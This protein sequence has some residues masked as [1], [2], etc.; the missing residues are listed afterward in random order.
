[1]SFNKDE[2]IGQIGQKVVEEY[3]N[4]MKRKGAIKDWCETKHFI[5]QHLGLN[6]ETD[7][8]LWTRKGTTAGSEVKCLAGTKW[9]KKEGKWSEQPLDTHCIEAWQDDAKTRRPGWI[10]AAKSNKLRWIF[11]YNRWQKKVYRYD[12]HIFYNKFLEAEP[13][14]HLVRCKQKK[15]DNQGWIFLFNME[16]KDWGFKDTWN[17]GWDSNPQGFGS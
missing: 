7:Y 17:G 8:V 3:F 14:L 1:M 6:Y 16:D 9:V 5:F 10:K 11:I 15:Q 12:A 4:F 2:K 13:S